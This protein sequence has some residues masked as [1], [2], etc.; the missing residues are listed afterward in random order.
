M[1]KFPFFVF[2]VTAIP[3]FAIADDKAPKQ[4]TPRQIAVVDVN[5]LLKNHA[6]LKK[7]LSNLGGEARLQQAKFES[8]LKSM[9]KKAEELKDLTAGTREYK[10][11]EE[12]LMQGKAK[13]QTD[14]AL[15]R[16]DF[17]QREA[18]LYLG[19]YRQ[20][21]SDVAKTAKSRGI[22]IVINVNRGEV[23]ADNPTEAAKRITDKVVWFDD[24]LDL[25]PQLE[26]RYAR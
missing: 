21:Q 16:K 3:L 13:I 1:F 17:E 15:T 2:L 14:I 4:K 7:E 20:I 24:S 19:V 8:Q 23:G 18:Q 10:T 12:E 26:D 5:R 9:S 11:L 25:T 6:K 22:V